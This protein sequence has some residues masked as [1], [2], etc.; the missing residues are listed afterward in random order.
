MV[1]GQYIRFATP[2]LIS[3]YQKWWHCFVNKSLSLHGRRAVI[4]LIYYN[5]QER[6]NIYTWPIERPFLAAQSF[7]TNLVQCLPPYFVIII[8]MHVCSFMCTISHNFPK[9]QTTVQLYILGYYSRVRI[10]LNMNNKCHTL[11][12]AHDVSLNMLSFN[13]YTVLLRVNWSV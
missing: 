6:S 5:L 10:G 13:H 3:I 12:I 4:K 2:L 1:H 7:N 8:N 9:L 11:P